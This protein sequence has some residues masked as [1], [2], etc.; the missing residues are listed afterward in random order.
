MKLRFLSRTFCAITLCSPLLAG[1]SGC[2]GEPSQPEPSAAQPTAQSL[3][4][5]S[6]G[7]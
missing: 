5:A 2:A 1:L 7:V 6:M 3:S 4:E